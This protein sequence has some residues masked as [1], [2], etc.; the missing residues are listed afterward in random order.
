MKKKLD[1]NNRRILRAILNKPWRQHP[2]KK[3]LYGHRPN[4]TKTIRVRR[5]RHTGFCRRKRDELISDILLWT[6]LHG[7]A[8]AG[9]PARTYIQQ[10]CTDTGWSLEDL[11]KRWTI[12]RS[13]GSGTGMSM[14]MV[15]HDD[16]DDESIMI[17]FDWYNQP[18][19]QPT[20]R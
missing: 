6:P 5:T 12:E 15:R 20:N 16:D 8:K 14:L 4:I 19:N 3:R 11:S 17:V 18:T 13:G 10:L 2:T 7:I 1:I 9:R